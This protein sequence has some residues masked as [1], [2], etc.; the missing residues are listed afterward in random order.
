[1]SLVLRPL[2]PRD[3]AS[4]DALLTAAYTPSTSMLD[5]LVRYHRLQPDGWMFLS[6]ILGLILKLSVPACLNKGSVLC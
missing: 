4:V 5:D 6:M 3:F 1:M 2:T